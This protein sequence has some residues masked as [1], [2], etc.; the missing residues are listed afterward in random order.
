MRASLDGSLAATLR[1]IRPS[2]SL[3]GDVSLGWS[4]AAGAS[5]LADA[6]VPLLDKRRF[7]G[8]DTAGIRTVALALASDSMGRGDQGGA[9]V[10]RV[11]AAT[12]TLLQRRQQG[13]AA[14][15][16]SVILALA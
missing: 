12:I 3:G 16:E 9:D 5:R 13:Q 7:D 14:I 15:G 11:A 4:L 2:G 1:D 8:P 6:C 10:L